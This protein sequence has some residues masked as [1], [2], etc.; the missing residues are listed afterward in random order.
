M[1]NDHPRVA[2]ATSV[3]NDKLPSVESLVGRIAD[4][5]TEQLNRGEQPDIE[6]YAQRYPD[7]AD[8]LRQALPALQALKPHTTPRPG[9][10]SGTDFKSVLHEA[11]ALGDFRIIREVGRGGMG[12][13]Y[14]A[15]QVSLGRRVA[16][17]VLPFSATMDAR[18]LQ[19][20]QNEA[21]AAAGLHH[22]N[23]VPVH[24]VGCER[25]VHFYAMQYIEG[26]SLAD[27]IA[28]LKSSV[29]RQPHDETT[30][31]R[32]A[33][34]PGSPDTAPMAR[35][36]TAH[37]TKDP[38]YFRTVAQLGIQA[39]EALD[40]AH[41]M[42]VIHRDIKPA[43]LML[44]DTGRLW[45]TDFGLAQVQSDTRLTLTGDLV[46]TLRY[47]SP[48][49]A[50]AKRAVVDHRTDIYSLG[51]TLFEL[52]TLGPTF[53][54]QDRQELLRQIAFEEPMLP[55]RLNRAIPAELEIIVLKAIEKNPA[56]RYATAKE[57]AEDLQRWLNH[58]TIRA[59]RASLVRRARQW[60][61]RHRAFVRAAT[62][63]LLAV[64]LLSCGVLWREISERAAIEG[65]VQSALVRADLLQE[66]ERYEEALGVL[67]VAESQLA[68]RGP[69]AL[70]QRLEERERDVRMLMGMRRPDCKSRQAERTPYSTWQVRMSCTLPHSRRTA[71]I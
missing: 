2:Q 55:R 35:I 21:R 8:L 27:L 45:V 3:C 34:A 69:A 28:S 47:M 37:S 6:D 36:S 17:K 13:V 10:V 23:I 15:E 7:I 20:F 19:R 65:A 67:T 52:L 53:T 63:L 56:D 48:E 54:G 16:L 58:E 33:D 12:L 46:G 29:G 42:G 71:W 30:P 62:V 50:L 25:G 1:T 38:R 26:Q 61:R 18:Q 57:L 59:R 40:Y 66:Q 49:Q 24:G 5:F 60:A 64:L 4:E 31:Y 41:Q 44:D 22:T 39:A 68:L 14:E 70:R 43:N 9:S 11:E 51:A 32:G